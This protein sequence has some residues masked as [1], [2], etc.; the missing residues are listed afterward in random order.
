MVDGFWQILDDLEEARVPQD[1]AKTLVDVVLGR[2][3]FVQEH[4]KKQA[5]AIAFRS[6][7][8]FDWSLNVISAQSAAVRS[9]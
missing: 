8:D 5:S 6:L 2:A 7:K 1:I 4:L 9:I 3:D